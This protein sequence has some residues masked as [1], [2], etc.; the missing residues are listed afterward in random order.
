MPDEEKD[1]MDASPEHNSATGIDQPQPPKGTKRD[2]LTA[3]ELL[4]EKLDSSLR[5][6]LTELGAGPF[7]DAMIAETVYVCV[8]RG[9]SADHINFIG[10][11][12]EQNNILVATD[13]HGRL[14]VVDA[15]A[16]TETVPEERL[17]EAGQLQTQID[18]QQ[19]LVM[20]QLQH[21]ESKLD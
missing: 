10:V 7:A 3:V 19:S 18:Q 17:H 5:S 9:I 2:A 12:P 13:Q 8:Q 21:C 1:N 16:A 14:A 6:R 4:R 15:F 20:H 11:G